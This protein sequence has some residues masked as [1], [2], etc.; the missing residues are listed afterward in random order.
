MFQ[1]D[2]GNTGNAPVKT[3]D[4]KVSGLW[5]SDKGSRVQSPPVIKDNVIYVNSGVV[6]ALSRADGTHLWSTE[7]AD[8]QS[9]AVTDDYLYRS[10][11]ELGGE[12]LYIHDR[13]DGIELE[14]YS[15]PGYMTAALAVADETAYVTSNAFHLEKQ[16]EH[17][18]NLYAITPEGGVEW[19]FDPDRDLSADG[20]VGSLPRHLTPAVTD[21]SVFITTNSPHDAE[22]EVL[23]AVSRTNGNEQWSTAIPN[24]PSAPISAADG[25]L[26]LPRVAEQGSKLHALSMDDGSEQWSVEMDRPRL[27]SIAVGDETVYVSCD[28][29]EAP[30]WSAVVRALS[31]TD[32]EEEWS[33]E[34]EDHLV[35]PPV[36]ID[37][38]VYVSGTDRPFQERG[39]I[40]ALSASDGTEQWHFETD[41]HVATSPVIVDGTIYIGSKREYV[42]ALE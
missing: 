10:V 13:K 30:D 42:Y 27:S 36:T 7:N 20:S 19:T 38:T 1:Y 9:I 28:T 22:N 26:Y 16:N 29:R 41:R 3:P 6:H 15:I 14:S 17:I 23:Y 33:Y 5:Q 39:D 34:T 21:E 32:G 8:T 2:S 37:D 25:T 35:G 31:A 24:A 4:G 12:R 11:D 40:Y 18:K